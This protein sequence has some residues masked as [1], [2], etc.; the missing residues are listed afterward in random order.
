MNTNSVPPPIRPA[1]PSTK[2]AVNLLAKVIIE[3]L[4]SGALII[5]ALDFYR[6]IETILHG[7][8]NKQIIL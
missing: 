2:Y 5:N 4:L 8:L 3:K 6:L 1:S 7:N